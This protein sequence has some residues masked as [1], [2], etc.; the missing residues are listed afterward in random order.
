MSQTATAN[1][2]D[3]GQSTVDAKLGHVRDED[4]IKRTPSGVKVPE[5]ERHAGINVLRRTVSAP[6]IVQPD[7]VV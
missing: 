2:A 6:S 7:S 4:G 1:A 3:F 5:D